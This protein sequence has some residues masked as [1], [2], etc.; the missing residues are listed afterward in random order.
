MAQVVDPVPTSAA[1]RVPRRVLRG[2]LK[3]GFG[4]VVLGWVVFLVPPLF[5]VSPLGVNL[6]DAAQSAGLLIDVV[7]I[8]V[9][10]VAVFGP[11]GQP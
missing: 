3:I 9:L 10:A 6:V 7:G 5:F 1:G 8:V 11:Y 4:L 2:W